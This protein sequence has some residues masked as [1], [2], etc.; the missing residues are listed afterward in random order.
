MEE[1][2]S[3]RIAKFGANRGDDL[4][5]WRQRF[6][7]LLELKQVADVVL[8]DVIA[9]N[10]PKTF[11]DDVKKKLARARMSLVQ[12]LGHKPLRTAIGEKISLKNVRK[13]Y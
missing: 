10:D 1:E 11:S 3:R 4:T 7:A 9:D 8:S 5:L 12:Y 6:E 13:A 2:L